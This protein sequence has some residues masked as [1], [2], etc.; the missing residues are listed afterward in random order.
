MF[1]TRCDW[2]SGLDTPKRLE[3]L[4]ALV[5]HWHGEP[6]RTATPPCV[7]DF[8]PPPLQWL[9]QAVG[10][11]A[12]AAFETSHGKWTSGE[13]VVCYHWLKHPL[14]LATDDQ[15]FVEFCNKTQG[16]CQWATRSQLDD[17]PVFR[18]E[19]DHRD[20]ESHM[21]RLTN[22]LLVLIVFELTHGPFPGAWGSMSMNKFRQLVAP[23][24]AV[25]IGRATLTTDSPCSIF[26]GEELAVF[27]GAMRDELQ[28]VQIAA[29]TTA[30]LRPLRSLTEWGS[31]ICDEDT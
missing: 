6:V 21:E 16:V 14:R 20:W 18:R 8:V 19:S 28:W 4:D 10:S 15:G 29:R 17:P 26:V 23:L 3:T 1:I 30:A 7:P 9:Y 5:R 24:A 12:E 11:H 27:S 2:P 25:D 22:Y 13:P 31:W